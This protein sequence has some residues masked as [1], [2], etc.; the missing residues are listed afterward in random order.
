MEYNICGLIMEVGYEKMGNTARIK[1]LGK[2]CLD[3][4]ALALRDDFSASVPY[5]ED[6]PLPVL[7]K[8]FLKRDSVYTVVLYSDTP[9]VSRK[10]VLDAVETLR[11]E[12]L[13]A[14]K[15]TRGYVF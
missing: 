9:L 15:M 6:T 2:S 1:V 5:R 7:L 4:V 10:S 14:L 13:N 3:W 11:S 8:P 12:G